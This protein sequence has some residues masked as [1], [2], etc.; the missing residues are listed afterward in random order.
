MPF[1]ASYAVDL[2]KGGKESW[3]LGMRSVV[4]ACAGFAFMNQSAFIANLYYP[5]DAAT[6][7]TPFPSGAFWLPLIAILA[8]VIM[9]FKLPNEGVQY[10]GAEDQKSTRPASSSFIYLTI[11]ALLV[12]VAVGFCYV[13][14][15]AVTNLGAGPDAN[16]AYYMS[17]AIAIVFLIFAV[18]FIITMFKVS[19]D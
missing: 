1:A 6:G 17:V 16:I 11:A 18:V 13:I 5:I 19:A 15:Q 2:F 10:A 9:I 8:A 4:G 14:Y 7:L 3:M 12:G